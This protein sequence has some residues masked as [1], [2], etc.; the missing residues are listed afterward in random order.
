[1]SSLKEFIA[2]I[3]LAG[4]HTSQ[5]AAM[6]PRKEK[7]R[8]EFCEHTALAERDKMFLASV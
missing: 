8:T 6:N 4:T 7:L 5:Y 1:M 2:V 3:S